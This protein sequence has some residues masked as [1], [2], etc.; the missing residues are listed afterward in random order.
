MDAKR[1]T[2]EFT[3]TLLE[4]EPPVWRRIEVPASYT[5][6]DLH[7]AIQDA[8]GWLDYHLHLFRVRDDITGATAEIGIPN[9]DPFL[10]D[11]AWLPGWEVP[12]TGYLDEP[13]DRATYEYDFGDGW[14][15]EVE[16]V[17]IVVGW[18]ASKAVH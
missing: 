12:V 9:P 14:V 6:W 8:M 10:G 3:V 1:S 13:G 15:H 18:V 2:L 17:A 7:V 5:F 4:V 16:L 11:P